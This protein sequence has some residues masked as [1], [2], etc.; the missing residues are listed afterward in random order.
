LSD[1]AERPRIAL[2]S[3][4]RLRLAALAALGVALLLTLYYPIGAYVAHV[5]D[6]DPA[7]AVGE[8]APGQ[9]RAAALA[10]ALIE[11]ETLTHRWVANDPFFLP[12]AWLDNMPAFQKGIIGALSRFAIEMSDQIGRMRGSSSIDPDLDKAA[13]L[14]KYPGTIWLFDLSTSWMPTASS[15]QQYRAAARALSAYNERLGANQAVFER[16]ADNLLATLD[17][18]GKDLGSSSAV[19][20][21][22]IADS[23]AFLIDTRADD[24]FYNVKGRMYAYHL[25]LRE[26]GQDFSN[27]LAERE[28]GAAWEQML[29]S[30]EAGA[31]LEPLIVANGDPDSLM[32]PSHLAAQGFY[33]LRARTQLGEI[34][35]ILLK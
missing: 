21:Q 33:L 30:F 19:L 23:P 35:N 22:H 13:G 25:L 31:R 18:I 29:A 10:A 26:L 2:P 1:E 11:R 3:D 32:I 14:L 20:D 34:A 8:T 27:I 15:E 7:F 5:V 6:D 16:R 4:N 28:L 9:S 17:R 12:P 24:I